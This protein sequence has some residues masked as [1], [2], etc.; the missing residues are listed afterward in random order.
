MDVLTTKSLLQCQLN[1]K[2]DYVLQT[3]LLQLLVSYVAGLQ[4]PWVFGA[5]YARDGRMHTVLHVLLSAQATLL[6]PAPVPAAPAAMAAARLLLRAAAVRHPAP[7][8]CWLR[9]TGT[10]LHAQTQTMGRRAGRHVSYSEKHL[11]GLV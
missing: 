8:P 6:L 3:A 2:V 4:R 9:L 11:A 1:N 10:P 5:L 7:A